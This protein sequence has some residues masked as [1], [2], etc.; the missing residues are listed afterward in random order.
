MSILHSSV[1]EIKSGNPYSLFF[2]VT[3]R[4]AVDL[5][6]DPVYSKIDQIYVLR[7]DNKKETINP[8]Y[9]DVL[10]DLIK[11]VNNH[12]SRNWSDVSAKLSKTGKIL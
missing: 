1:F 2:V 10:I 12:L 6:I 7:K 11:E 8:K 9:P 3:E 4:Y 5:S